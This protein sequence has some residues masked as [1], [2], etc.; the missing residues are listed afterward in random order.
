L[1]DVE[2]SDLEQSVKGRTCK[3]PRYR[4]E[5]LLGQIK[6][7]QKSPP[8]EDWSAVEPPWPNDDWSDVAPKARKWQGTRRRAKRKRAKPKRRAS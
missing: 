8:L 7:G 6:P 2:Y 5:D 1:E 3:T 4:L